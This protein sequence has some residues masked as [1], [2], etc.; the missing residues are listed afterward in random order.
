M[1]GPGPSNIRSAVKGC[2]RDGHRKRTR[3]S[4]IAS[5][6]VVLRNLDKHYA[7]SVWIRDPH[8]D[9]TPR[10]LLRLTKNRYPGR[11]QPPVLELHLANLNPEGQV[12][13]CGEH[14]EEDAI[15]SALL[16]GRSSSI[17]LVWI[18]TITVSLPASN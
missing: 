12:A 13:P 15:C 5:Q 1:L 8:F 10:L 14:G 6:R 2:G 4:L 18:R 17:W 7:H 11:Q 9:Q 16:R 3:S